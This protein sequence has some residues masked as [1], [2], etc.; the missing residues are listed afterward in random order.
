M[1]FVVDIFV[2]LEEVGSGGGGGGG[3]SNKTQKKKR[4]KIGRDSIVGI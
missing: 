3:V 2:C 1:R 4:G